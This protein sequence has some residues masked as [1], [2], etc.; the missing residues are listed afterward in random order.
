MSGTPIVFHFIFCV[1]GRERERVSFILLETMELFML[2]QFY[3]RPMRM[4]SQKVGNENARKRIKIL[5]L[6]LYENGR[7]KIQLVARLSSFS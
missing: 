1:R 6:H 5:L 3:L 4:S 7:H 2:S